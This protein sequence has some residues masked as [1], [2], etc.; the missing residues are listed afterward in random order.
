MANLIL[1]IATSHTPMLTLPAELWASY[2]QNDQRNR[3]LAFPPQGH[4]M[5]YDEGLKSV[6]PEISAR[7]RGTEPY[8]AQAEA[9]QRA[10]DE[11]SATLRAVNPDVTV[12]IGDDQDEWFFE[13]NMPALSVF[14][15][16]TAPLIPRQMPPGTRDAAVIEAIRRGYGDV[17]MDVPVAS[18][19]GRY[20]IEYLCEH[21]FD[22]AHMRYVKQPYGGRIARRY[23]T[24]HGELDYV[25]ET[26]PRDQ[27]LPHAFSFIVKRLFDNNPRPILPVFQ[28]TCYHPNQPT[29]RRAFATGEA[30]A[31]ALA[32]WKEPA[33]VAVVASGGLSHFVVDGNLDR[34][35]P[36]ALQQR[37]G[38]GLGA[39][40]P[41]QLLSPA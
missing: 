6:T 15:G 1:G 13:D 12:I 4:V 18:A 3:E 33:A 41:A 26:P 22:V 19:F 8:R 29:P 39:I 5:S 9:C 2:A 14:W 37:D 36:N 25:R 10:L 32:E 17:P 38:A 11:L 27:G 24:R 35:L 34:P 31:A 23:P 40:Q 28:N 30:I 7:F 16:D 20:L 21:D